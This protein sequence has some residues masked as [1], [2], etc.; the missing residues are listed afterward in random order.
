MNLVIGLAFLCQTMGRFHGP[1]EYFFYELPMI[2][3]L[4]FAFKTVRCPC[5]LNFH[6]QSISFF[7]IT[8]QILFMFP[9][10]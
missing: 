2:S 9:Y 10:F 4:F 8:F 6:L 7:I 3:L 1:C 5:S